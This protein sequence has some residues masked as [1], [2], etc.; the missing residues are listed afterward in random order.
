M[1]K[2]RIFSI[3]ID[4]KNPLYVV[5]ELNDQH[6][7]YAVN[8]KDFLS[9]NVKSDVPI[10]CLLFDIIEGEDYISYSI[11]DPIGTIKIERGLLAGIFLQ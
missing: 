1:E 8:Q 2:R 10:E 11:K 6:K 4:K 3:P 5:C 7:L 9:A